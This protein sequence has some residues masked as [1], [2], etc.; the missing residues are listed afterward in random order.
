M[1]KQCR[2]EKSFARQRELEDGLLEYLSAV[3]FFDMEIA[4]LCRYLNIPRKT[5]YRYFGSKED[6]LYA[7]IDHRL[8]DMTRFVE[9]D[10]IPS[11]RT[12]QQE[13]VRFFTFWKSQQRF[14][15][16]MIQNY[17]ATIVMARAMLETN[18]TA[19]LSGYLVQ[20]KEQGGDYAVNFLVS[21][22][23]SMVFQWHLSGYKTTTD[24]LSKIT[25]SLFNYPILGLLSYE[26]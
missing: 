11:A 14:L 22:M 5:F 24:D 6:A 16:I 7:L 1:Y 25:E 8:M 2:T 4:D 20:T 13:A 9:D 15:E 21:G 17:L 19:R 23:M 26:K 10:S 3:T 18:L 12:L